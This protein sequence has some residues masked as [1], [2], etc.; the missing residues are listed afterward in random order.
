MER[1]A[2]EYNRKNKVSVQKTLLAHPHNNILYRRIILILQFDKQ[3]VCRFLR[4]DRALVGTLIDEPQGT[5]GIAKQEGGEFLQAVALAVREVIRNE[6][7][8]LHAVG[9]EAVAL[10]VGAHDEWGHDARKVEARYICRFGNIR[11]FRPV[12]TAQG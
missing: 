1:L 9:G 6:L 5:F 12:H 3:Y 2:S 10:L 4:Y 8:A 7:G 11:E